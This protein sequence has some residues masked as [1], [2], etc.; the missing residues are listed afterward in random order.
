MTLR[1]CGD[2]WL[3]WAWACACCAKGELKLSAAAEV[4]WGRPAKGRRKGIKGAPFKGLVAWAK[5][6]GRGMPL[7]LF[8]LLIF[9]CCSRLARSLLATRFSRKFRVNWLGIWGMFGRE[10]LITSVAASGDLSSWLPLS[11]P[12]VD[13]FPPPG[14]TD[15]SCPEISL[16]RKVNI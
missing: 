14:E 2:C 10:G 11:V 16:T 12:S 6:F 7:G 13:D 4:V 8:S 9:C 1:G 3:S 5:G 15:R